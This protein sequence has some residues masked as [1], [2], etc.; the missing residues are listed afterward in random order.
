MSYKERSRKENSLAYHVAGFINL[1]FVLIGTLF[2]MV[3]VS[4]IENE[5]FG[6]A[7]VMI[8]GIFMM[9]VGLSNIIIMEGGEIEDEEDGDYQS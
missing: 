4:A 1:M 9:I 7:V 5:T 8:L 6:P 2:A 3:G